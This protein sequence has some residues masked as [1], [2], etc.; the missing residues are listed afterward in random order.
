[1]FSN[2]VNSNHLDAILLSHS[3]TKRFYRGAVAIDELPTIV[4]E[5]P[6]M[7]ITNNQFSDQSG[8]HW[9][10]I[11]F[12]A[13][14][15]RISAEDNVGPAEFYDPIAWGYKKYPLAIEQFMLRNCNGKIVENLY[16]HQPD[17]SPLCGLY[18]AYIM[19]KRCGGLSFEQCMK[20]LSR[21]N[22]QTNDARVRNY[23]YTH[24]M[25]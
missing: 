19:D 11:M 17:T 24:L 23:L 21:S 10:L 25:K 5:Y 14:G 1:M 2:G 12:G 7:Y 13:G 8:E 9:L 22:L 3:C 6:S 15:R 18:C 4:T 20:S 16:P